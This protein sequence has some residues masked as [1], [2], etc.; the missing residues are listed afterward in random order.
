[1]CLA[2]AAA[3]CSPACNSLGD[4]HFSLFGYST[5]PNYDTCIRTVYVPIFKNTTMYKNIEFDLTKAV[6]REIELKTPYKVVSCREDADTELLGKII[7][8]NKSVM[9]MNQLG[10]IRQ[11]QTM[12][13]AE[14]VWRDLRPGFEQSILSKQA[15]GRPDPF[16]PPPD[17]NAPPLPPPPVLAQS[18]AMFEPEL[19]GSL[20]SAQVQ[21]VDRL[22]V[23]IVSM[24][25][26]W[27]DSSGAMPIGPSVPVMPPG[28]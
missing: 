13:T 26:V 12:L 16:A 28:Q 18:V 10:E 3:F 27:N 7:N 22:A 11:A 17:P 25:E 14:L 4:G 9:L 1:M 5:Q 8:F 24:M 19:G 21:N 15:P 2:A 20:T 6:I 23:Q